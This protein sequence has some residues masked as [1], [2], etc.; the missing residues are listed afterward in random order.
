MAVCVLGKVIVVSG[1]ITKGGQL[2]CRDLIGFNVDRNSWTTYD[3][4]GPIDS[5]AIAFH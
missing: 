3:V 4:K 5:L 1:G 2:L